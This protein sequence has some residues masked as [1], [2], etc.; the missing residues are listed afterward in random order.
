MALG[1]SA[2]K[3]VELVLREGLVLVGAGLVAGL[4]GA[5]ALQRAMA[6]EVYGVRALEPAVL[7]LVM[8]TLA[9]V[10]LVACVLPA[11]RAL[12]VDPVRVLQ[13]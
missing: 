1:S 6:S 11:R 13:E 4:A 2:G 8:G 9:V 5:V 12:Q 10:G 7:G 3:V